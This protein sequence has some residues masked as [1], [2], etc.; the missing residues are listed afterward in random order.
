M[1]LYGGID[2][3]PKLER[4][5]A[6]CPQGLTISCKHEGPGPQKQEIPEASVARV[7]NSE[8]RAPWRATS[9][10]LDLLLGCHSQL[11]LRQVASVDM[12]TP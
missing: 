12:A 5:K 9:M 4:I 1:S 7:G 6:F 10:G 2:L 8:S 11:A 3:S